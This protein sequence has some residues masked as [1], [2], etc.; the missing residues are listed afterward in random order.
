MPTKIE[1]DV[2]AEAILKGV[3]TDK[4]KFERDL[5]RFF[6][7]IV[8]SSGV[9]KIA[10]PVEFN[11]GEQ[12]KPA[13]RQGLIKQISQ[14]N[15]QLRRLINTTIAAGASK[16]VPYGEEFNLLKD[17][18]F[19]GSGELKLTSGELGRLRNFYTQLQS[20]LSTEVAKFSKGRNIYEQILAGGKSA[21]GPGSITSK[22]R[23]ELKRYVASLE[24][25]K[26]QYDQVI[27]S[28]IS[29]EKRVEGVVASPF[30]LPGLKQS[31]NELSKI[32]GQLKTITSEGKA[33]QAAYAQSIISEAG[34]LGKV[35]TI[36]RE[37]LYAVNEELI[38]GRTDERYISASKRLKELD[39][40][41]RAA[42]IGLLDFGTTVQQT[43]SLFRQ[44]FRYALGYGALYEVLSAVRALI[45][46]VLDLDEALKDIQAISAAT[47]AQLESI[48]QAIKRV[49]L[50]TKFTTT[51][52]ANAAKVL[53]QAGV[54]PDQINSVLESTALFATATGSAIEI[55]A[56]LVTTMRDVFKELDDLSIANQLTKAV[57]ISKLTAEDL[58]VILSI[59]AQTAD[60]YRL[61]SEQFL[62]AAT[63]LRNAGLKAS[64]A[65]T[66]F[67]QALIEIF[68]PDQKAI[69]IITERYKQLGESV[70]SKEVRDRFFSLQ[71]KDNPL[72][73]VLEELRRLGFA[74]TGRKYF[75]RTFDVRA[76]NALIAMINN[77]S[78]LRK[79][80]HE[81][82]FGQPALIAAQTQ[83]E[84][85]TNSL[86]NLGAAFTV[87]S[88][89]LAS[90]IVPSIENF[91]DG[92]TDAI[93][94]VAEL[95]S[96]LKSISGTGL[97]SSIVPALIAG[98]AA[99][100]TGPRGVTGR[101]LRFVGGSALGGTVAAGTG[102][103]GGAAG[104]SPQAT[105]GLEF[106]STLIFIVGTFFSKIYSK[107]KATRGVTVIAKFAAGLGL[108][109]PVILGITTIVS[110]IGAL[111]AFFSGNPLKEA[112][113][114]TEAAL[115]E[116]EE[117]K[118]KYL[119]SV[120]EFEEFRFSDLA[121]GRLARP[122]ST[123]ANIEILENNFNKFQDLY[124]QFLGRVSEKNLSEVNKILQQ[125]GN[126]GAEKNSDIRNTLIKQLSALSE[127]DPNILNDPQA[128]DNFNRLT[129]LSSEIPDTVE[130]FVTDLLNQITIIRE[131]LQRGSIT[132]DQQRLLD[133]FDSVISDVPGALGQLI[134]SM[135][136]APQEAL[137]KLREITEAAGS[138]AA[139]EINK[140]LQAIRESNRQ[141]AEKFAEQLIQE[142]R[143]ARERILSEIAKLGGDKTPYQRAFTSRLKEAELQKQN[144]EK[145]RK[146]LEEQGIGVQ[147]P[148]SPESLKALGEQNIAYS[149]SLDKINKSISD[150]DKTISIFDSSLNFLNGLYKEQSIVLDESKKSLEETAKLRLKEFREQGK[151]E[152]RT[153]AQL[154]ARVKGLAG[155]GAANI[156]P[157]LKALYGSEKDFNDLINTIPLVK[158]INDQR[159]G[160]A[161][162]EYSDVF[163]AL[164][165]A[166]TSYKLSLERA[167]ESTEEVVAPNT[168]LSKR[169]DELKTELEKAK[170]TVAGR[171]QAP[172]ILKELF[173]TQI[174]IQTDLIG[175]YEVQKAEGTKLE[176]AQRGILTATRK[177]NSLLEQYNREAAQLARDIVV[178]DLRSSIESLK[179]EEDTIQRVLQQASER[180]DAEGTSAAEERLRTV[181]L[182]RADAEAKLIQIREGLSDKET[183]A[184]EYLLDSFQKASE[185]T[186]QGAK[187]FISEANKRLGQIKSGVVTK[188]SRDIFGDL[189]TPNP[190]LAGVRE[191]Y[192][193]QP[194][195][196]SVVGN[197]KNQSIAIRDVMDALVEKRN[198]AIE[199][200]QTTEEL[201]KITEEY[202]V[203][204][205]ELAKD[206]GLVE[207]QLQRVQQGITE[208]IQS[209]L[210]PHEIALELDNLAV[211]SK[212]LDKTLRDT[213]V[214]GL[215]STSKAFADNV[216]NARK[217]GKDL[218]DTVKQT[219]KNVAS[220]IIQSQI[221][222]LLQNLFAALPFGGPA[223]GAPVPTPVVGGAKVAT[224][225]IIKGPGTGTS[226]SVLG[227]IKSSSGTVVSGIAVSNN[228]AI[229]NAG[230]VSNIG[231][232][233]IN[234]LNR[235]F[236]KKFAAGGSVSASSNKSGRGVI[237]GDLSVV[238]ENNGTPQN[239]TNTK[240]DFDASGTIIKVVTEDIGR[241]GGPIDR[242]IQS[243]YKI[244]RR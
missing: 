105:A 230:A 100:A 197:L 73:A 12:I 222:A 118:N 47:S 225:G 37:K 53:S 22:E 84:S 26:R 54:G 208:A 31:S 210:N 122:G 77:I 217:W 8:R 102:A 234:K 45:G 36:D 130:S 67:R 94:A 81:L 127:F 169:V 190:E 155:T 140:N 50:S 30:N 2:I 35:G 7:K 236:Y 3:E 193:L 135:T 240:V 119:K 72:V 104:L 237:M 57:N 112:R 75:Q 157:Q 98:G 151:K 64:T 123:A 162:Y 134:V 126:V 25:L 224:G 239:V 216:V 191:G 231:E 14:R 71:Q 161:G 218:S 97:S 24:N 131:N 241:G 108:R 233:N 91:V 187:N 38:R 244:N 9:P 164:N 188:E 148:F 194:T 40:A 171:K 168:A 99:A 213:I 175:Q 121:S 145:S 13:E 185:A 16:K 226:D 39:K 176:R 55:A 219:L 221:N 114:R 184:R 198:V 58:K 116:V 133:A 149:A 87:L 83:M 92:M 5:N 136:E 139:T 124:N 42:K 51:E 10:L 154:E 242:T 202:D 156:A 182:K 138:L 19:G 120:S 62:A 150:L 101:I 173:D 228:E 132:P 69:K 86:K 205:L 159:G 160:I 146:V 211:S 103:A 238:V 17:I 201:R 200:A 174:K 60:R 41:Q 79:A 142:S 196:Q 183:V 56:D 163:V 61:T 44:F 49:A 178:A 52:I 32:I 206:L 147:F 1:L 170:T 93:K 89:N 235:A 192:G 68:S 95:D 141:S 11:I 115:K 153:P 203:A 179:R 212:N 128:R 137:K 27:K 63:V 74:G 111:A 158:Q 186:L 109:N 195:S 129:E 209:G 28:F 29:T 15:E 125:L 152:F 76:E 96:K 88:S 70:T 229:M 43:N 166:I 46:G 214:S 82:T 207:G 59:G 90:D 66:G 220:S 21:F 18:A 65:A 4:G 117:A 106:V 107:L 215:D 33:Q 189:Y 172:A 48:S 165:K 204:L 243:K 78:E 80:E 6:G 113:A 34:G 227:V 20:L 167:K 85:L 143:E 23:Q 110:L 232:G 180:L 199:D 223:F 177:R 144:L 181:L